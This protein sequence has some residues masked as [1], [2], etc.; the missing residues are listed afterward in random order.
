MQIIETNHELIGD[1]RPITKVI[2]GM[3]E[4]AICTDTASYL[5]S[6]KH[7]KVCFGIQSLP[8][9]SQR[10]TIPIAIKDLNPYQTRWAIT[11]RVTHKGDKREYTNHRGVGRVFNFDIVDIKGS[12]T[13]VT[14]FNEVANVHFSHIQKDAM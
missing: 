5:A 2:E 3:I 13:H 1:A 12:K 8:K 4:P 9:S 14:S 11:S 6:T 7:H 10:P